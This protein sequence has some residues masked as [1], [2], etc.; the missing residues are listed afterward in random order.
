[1]LFGWD[2]GT[3]GG[4]IVMPSFISYVAALSM[5][6]TVCLLMCRAY[7]ISRYPNAD[8]SWEREKLWH[9]IWEDSLN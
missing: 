2:I 1:M 5:E 9:S 8:C 4:V 6:V 7:H 3:I